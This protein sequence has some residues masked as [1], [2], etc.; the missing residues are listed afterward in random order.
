LERSPCWE[1]IAIIPNGFKKEVPIGPKGSISTDRV[2]EVIIVLRF[3]IKQ[4]N[5]R[6]IR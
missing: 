1:H 3:Q 6:T 4:S 2:V 5:K